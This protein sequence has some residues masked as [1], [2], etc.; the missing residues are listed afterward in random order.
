LK[1]YFILGLVVILLTSTFSS[2]AFAIQPSPE[3]FSKKELHSLSLSQAKF[4]ESVNSS[5]HQT[6]W[7]TIANS[8]DTY[9]L[10]TSEDNKIHFFKTESDTTT[11]MLVENEIY[12]LFKFE[13]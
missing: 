6:T 8:P 2:M 1:K 10:K 11:F 4:S 12:T 3:S 7:N 9:L 5:L 13:V